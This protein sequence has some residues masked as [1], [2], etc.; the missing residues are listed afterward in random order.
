MKYEFKTNKM[1]IF[2]SAVSSNFKDCRDALASDLRQAG[3]GEV[4]VQEDFT[5]GGRTLLEKLESYIDSCDRVIFLIGDAL[6]FLPSQY[7]IPNG[8]PNRSYT[9]WEYFFAMGERLSG[10]RASRKDAFVYIA[11]DEFLATRHADQSDENRLLQTKFKEQ[12][13]LSGEDRQ[14]FNSLDELRLLVLKDG[15]R[16]PATTRKPSNLPYSSLGKLFKGRDNILNDLRNRIFNDVKANAPVAK[17]AL[18]QSSKQA[19]CGLGGIGK[20]R[21]AIEYAF[22]NSEKYNALLF[23][24]ADSPDKLKHGI[25]DLAVVLDLKEANSKQDEEAKYLAAMRWML[26]HPGWFLILDNVDDMNAASACEELIAKLYG[27]HVIITSRINI[28]SMGGIEELDINVLDEESSKALLLERTPAR[29]KTPN[30]DAFALDLAKRLDGLALG[31]EQAGAF[32]NSSMCSI[33]D[34][35]KWWK[36]GETEVLEWYDSRV[37]KYPMSVAVT[38]NATMQ[39]LGY[40]GE[41]MLRLLSVFEASPIPQNLIVGNHSPAIIQNILDEKKIIKEFGLRDIITKLSTYSMVKRSTSEN[42]VSLNLHRVVREITFRSIQLEEEKIKYLETAETLLAAFAPR[43]ADRFENW[44]IWKLLIPHADFIWEELKKIPNAKL[45]SELLHGR[46]LY[47][48]GQRNFEHALNLHREY[49]ELLEQQLGKNHP[50]TFEALNDYALCLPASQ[51]NL[52]MNLLREAYEGLSHAFEIDQE[53]LTEIFLLEAGLNIA[54]RLDAENDISNESET[55]LRKCISGFERL[56]KTGMPEWRELWA[57]RSLAT[58]KFLQRNFEE[59]IEISRETFY[60]SKNSMEL[61][62]KHKDTLDSMF[63]YADFILLEKKYED[64]ENLFLECL[65]L[66]EETLGAG[67]AETKNTLEVLLI[68]LKSLGKRTEATILNRE[69]FYKW[70]DELGDF[71]NNT[72]WAGESLFKLLQ[73]VNEFVEARS[74]ETLLKQIS[75]KDHYNQLLNQESSTKKEILSAMRLLAE[76][77][78]DNGQTLESERLYARYFEENNIGN[79]ESEDMLAITYNN[80]GLVLREEGK[81]NESL[82]EYLKALNIDEKVRESNHPK[83]AHRLNNISIV[84]LM[85]N[86]LD[87]CKRNLSRAWK[88]KE[89]KHDVT[90]LRILFIRT[91]LCFVENKSPSIYLGQMKTLFTTPGWYASNEVDNFWNVKSL[92]NYLKTKLSIE[93]E[94]FLETIVDSLNAG[95]HFYKNKKLDGINLWDNITEVPLTEPWE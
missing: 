63:Q 82:V 54:T 3:A 7:E 10:I 91:A 31:L 8:S 21:L 37:M 81:L 85:L 88:I 25:A 69:K 47:Y 18:T 35:L 51:R 34:Y 75:Q 87:E 22:E 12:I 5:Q 53:P 2:I 64:S 40:S 77:L 68:L 27:G 50:K 1:K 11:T 26:D 89:L 78:L 29:L 52:Q 13:L 42:D 66:R 17:A 57:K 80:Y 67:H 74:L 94:L 44:A 46:A 70:K 28:W 39:K 58:V 95:S 41:S 79:F 83:I 92:L 19:L 20:T 14:V 56:R 23:V 71:H 33:E 16:L 61:G 43:Q 36:E 9:Q 6:G 65:R 45:K 86:R 49:H 84:L 38:W 55:L 32:I 73:E 59:A 76:C 48:M 72:I 24:N 62:P 4:K 30:D 93:Q 90:S 60:Q 15:F